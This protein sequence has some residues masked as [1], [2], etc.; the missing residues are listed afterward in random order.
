MKFIC[1]ESRTRLV[2]GKSRLQIVAIKKKVVH[3]F[4]ARE[5]EINLCEDDVKAEFIVC[6]PSRIV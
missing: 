6:G 5:A 2:I 4:E 1:S 3:K